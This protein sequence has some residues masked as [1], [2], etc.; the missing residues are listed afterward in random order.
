M[1]AGAD[2][3]A[4]DEDDKTPL[5]Y[6]LDSNKGPAAVALLRNAATDPD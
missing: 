4:R 5:Y 1:A 6:A 2:I 3:E